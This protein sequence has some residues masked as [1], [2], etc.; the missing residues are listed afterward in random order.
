[1]DALVFNLTTAGLLVAMFRAGVTLLGE[2][3]TRRR[4]APWG[5]VALTVVAV[6]GIVTQ[7]CWS[8][9]MDALDSDPGK[10]GWYRVVTSV[11]MQN[12]GV[13][14]AAWNIV[15]LAVIAALAQWF[16]GTPLMFGL[17]A[18]GILLPSH[19]DQLFGASGRST[20]PRNF[21]G[22]SGA[23]Y[24]LAATL[25]GALLLK[26]SARADRDVRALALAAAA[27]VAGTAMWFAQSNGHGLVTV[28]GFFVGILVGIVPRPA[29]R[30]H[31]QV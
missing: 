24:F 21:A 27:P 14:G 5:A 7:V 3:T 22:S 8:G 17:F 2:D 1:V 23:T 6:A 10:P 16:W 28:Y 9:A 30:V 4:G 12:G 13:A 20:D 19:I 29:A 11:F 31:A 25:A 15:T 18:A 26:A